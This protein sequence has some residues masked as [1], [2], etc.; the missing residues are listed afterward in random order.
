MN[1]LITLFLLFALA[2]SPSLRAADDNGILE[3]REVGAADAATV[4]I[5]MSMLGWGIGLTAGIA[6]LLIL[7]PP[8]SETSHA[9]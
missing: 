2:L 6:T 4:A 3:S 5:D 1:R 9:H 7:I 8:E